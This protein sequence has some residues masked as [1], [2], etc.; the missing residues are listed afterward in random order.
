MSNSFVYILFVICILIFFSDTNFYNKNAL[1][2]SNVSSTTGHRKSDL[3]KCKKSKSPRGRP[4]TFYKSGY[5]EKHESSNI[6]Q[7]R[8]RGN[9]FISVAKSVHSLLVLF[10]NYH[11]S[12]SRFDTM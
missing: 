8:N 1:Q 12:Y 5:R 7:G 9:G 10:N 11:R 2:K 6:K 4:P 3:L